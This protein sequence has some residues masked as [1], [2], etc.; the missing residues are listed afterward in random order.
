MSTTDLTE[1]QAKKKAIREEAHKLRNELPE[2]D[3]LSLG[4]CKTLVESEEYKNAKTILWYLDARSEVRTR[5]FI[6][7][8]LQS[9]K[10]IIVPYCVD[11][12]LHR[13]ARRC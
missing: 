2:K 13:R 8:A 10:K 7:S 4:I 3:S 12:F 9:D 6:P 11:G 5:H 1:F